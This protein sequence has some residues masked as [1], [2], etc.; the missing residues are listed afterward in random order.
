[1][2]AG[3]A[4][5]VPFLP[6]MMREGLRA[7]FLPHGHR[8]MA[9]KADAHPAPQPAPG[10]MTSLSYAPAHTPLA[11]WRSVHNRKRAQAGT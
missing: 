6:L 7:S 10:I 11:R 4:L 8:M 3:P 5:A 2:R 1:M 9:A